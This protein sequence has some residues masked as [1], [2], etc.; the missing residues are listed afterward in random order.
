MHC[1]FKMFVDSAKMA[2]RKEA[3]YVVN[4]NYKMYPEISYEFN[5]RDYKSI[6]EITLIEK[7]QGEIYAAE[8]TLPFGDLT[9]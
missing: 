7:D 4:I 2:K 5:A 8:L 1:D 6:F 9:V 3:Q